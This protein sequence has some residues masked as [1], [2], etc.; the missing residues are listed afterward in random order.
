MARSAE[1][2]EKNNRDFFLGYLFVF[3]SY[4]ILGVLGYIGF[5]GVNFSD[6]YISNVGLD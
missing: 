1:N 4:I 6:Y 3:I 5:M 2:P